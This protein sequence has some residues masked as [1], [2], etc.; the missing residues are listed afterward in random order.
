MKG[1]LC[2]TTIVT[3]L[4]FRLHNSA[5]PLQGRVLDGRGRK[6]LVAVAFE[7]PAGLAAVTATRDVDCDEAEA[8]TEDGAAVELFG[9]PPITDPPTTLV[10]NTLP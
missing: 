9:G 8:E 10:T 1:L 4:S 2:A 7:P 3:L 5:C 6:L